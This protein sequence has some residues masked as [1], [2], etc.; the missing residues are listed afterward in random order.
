M[1]QRINKK[2][3]KPGNEILSKK[4]DTSKPTQ[5]SILNC[6]S[7][8]QFIENFFGDSQTE[9]LKKSESTCNENANGNCASG[10][11]FHRK[12]DT[13]NLVHSQLKK[14]LMNQ[15]KH[16]INIQSGAKKF[17][18]NETSANATGGDPQPQISRIWEATKENPIEMANNSKFLLNIFKCL[19]NVNLA[20]IKEHEQVQKSKTNLENRLFH[21]KRVLNLKKRFR[22]WKQAKLE[23][24]SMK[25]FSF[26]TIKILENRVLKFQKNMRNFSSILNDKLDNLVKRA[27]LTLKK[28]TDSKISLKKVKKPKLKNEDKTSADQSEISFE[29]GIISKIGETGLIIKPKPIKS[30]QKG[31]NSNFGAKERKLSIGRIP[32]VCKNRLLQMSPFLN[33]FVENPVRNQK[34][35]MKLENMFGKS[36]IGQKLLTKN[37]EKLN[38]NKNSFIFGFQSRQI[39][40]KLDK[41]FSK[42]KF[43]SSN[44]RKIFFCWDGEDNLKKVLLELAK[45]FSELF[46]NKKSNSCVVQKLRIR[47]LINWE[48]DPNL[49]ALDLK[50]NDEVANLVGKKWAWKSPSNFFKFRRDLVRNNRISWLNSTEKKEIGV[51]TRDLAKVAPGFKFEGLGSVFQSEVLNGKVLNRVLSGIVE[52]KIVARG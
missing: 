49:L 52:M 18:K 25:T 48:T 42:L 31:L 35:K 51:E 47:R 26:G 20:Q 41:R 9:N 29:P 46:Q 43:E 30:R 19:V 50:L 3:T 13:E 34:G 36:K 28:A 8:F 17:V 12:G 37:N 22:I 10:N 39:Q 40:Q 5:T 24:L 27:D 21:V 32:V 11:C 6:Q 16:E 45:H 33:S 44:D 38:K 1:N 14:M 7:Q 2:F 23:I 15:L 4:I